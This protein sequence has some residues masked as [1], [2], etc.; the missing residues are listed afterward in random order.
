MAFCD[1]EIITDPSR[2][3]CQ[4]DKGLNGII[5]TTQDTTA[6]YQEGVDPWPDV[7]LGRGRTLVV[8]R[9]MTAS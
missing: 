3:W 7:G 8:L 9:Y 5:A 4:C 1:I 6:S 2:E